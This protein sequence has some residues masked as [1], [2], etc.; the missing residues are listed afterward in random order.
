MG[1]L[2][3]AP[4]KWTYQW[5]PR[6]LMLFLAKRMGIETFVE[7]GTEFG[8]TAL[9]AS[10]HFNRVCTC[11]ASAKHF[12]IAQQRLKNAPNVYPALCE[13]M[14]WL[15]VVMQNSRTRR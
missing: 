15:A 2:K 6:E 14:P 8:S 3:I 13:S 5:V 7:T 11:E 10:Q 1:S 4:T 9:W 12:D